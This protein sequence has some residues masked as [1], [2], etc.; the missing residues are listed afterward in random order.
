MTAE[1]LSIIFEGS[2]KTEEVPED[3]GTT[4]IVLV[5][6]KSKKRPDNYRPVSLTFYD[7]MTSWVDEM[8]M[9]VAYLGF[10]KASD[11]FPIT[12]S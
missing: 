1:L 4:S 5:F 11:L 9:D 8:G 3:W 12:T 10:S 6:K 2:W 7:V